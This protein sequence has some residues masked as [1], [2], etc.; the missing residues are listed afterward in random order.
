MTIPLINRFG[1]LTGFFSMSALK[2]ELPPERLSGIRGGNLLLVAG[3]VIALIEN[4]AAILA[5]LH[6][7]SLFQA[8]TLSIL[9]LIVNALLIVFIFT[10][11]RMAVW[12]EWTLFLVYFVMYQMFYY[13]WEYR[14]G[15]IR[16]LSAINAITT[17][18]IL[19]TYLNIFQAV[20]ISA[21]NVVGYFFVSLYAIKFAGQPGNIQREMLIALCLVP[22][23]IFINVVS[24]RLNKKKNRTIMLNQKLQQAN[25]QLK[26][27][28]EELRANNEYNELELE[29]AGEIQSILFSGD[30]PDAGE[31]DMEVMSK[32]AERVSGDF[33]DFYSSGGHLN[34]LS[35]FDVSGHGIAPALITIYAK[36]LIY[37][38]FQK[39]E[40]RVFSSA[41]ESVSRGLDEQLAAAELYMIGVM[42]RFDG[43]RVEYINAGHPD[44]LHFQSDG[45]GTVTVKDREGSFKSGPVGASVP[46]A[47]RRCHEFMVYAGDMLVIYS[48]GLTE[49]CNKNGEKF[50]TERLC[51]ALN[52]VRGESASFAMDWLRRVLERFTANAVLKDDITVIIAVKKHEKNKGRG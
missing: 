33:F 43:D 42:L 1:F 4:F 41:I 28:N 50:G 12:H 29:I 40:G 34:G 20:L 26:E 39:S 14:L 35:L 47:E 6:R 45:R 32:K 18:A 5:G 24:W 37:R 17:A 11:K 52:S 27:K 7:V 31:W 9:V 2:A 21:A 49:C 48:D 30:K 23:F 44:I 38:S 10:R 51:N 22:V 15:D 46:G 13:V 36:Q 16:L 3:S 25:D 19:L 8:A